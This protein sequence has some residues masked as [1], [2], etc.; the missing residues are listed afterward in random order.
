MLTQRELAWLSTICF[1]VKSTIKRKKNVL[2]IIIIL[3]RKIKK[4]KISMYL[5]THL[6]AQLR[7]LPG[8]IK[9]STTIVGN[10]KKSAH[11]LQ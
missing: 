1:K 7:Q 3:N 5:R 9:N 6:R 10:L 4:F 2:Y 8:E 11:L